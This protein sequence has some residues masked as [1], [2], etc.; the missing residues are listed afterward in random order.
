MFTATAPTVRRPVFGIRAG[1][2]VAI[3]ARSTAERQDVGAAMG[4]QPSN[5]LEAL[6]E[7]TVVVADTGTAS[8]S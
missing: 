7:M 8:V 4:G 2:R 1:N 5:Q 6:Q 3:R